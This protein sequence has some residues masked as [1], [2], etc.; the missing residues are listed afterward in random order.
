MLMLMMFLI[1][2]GEDKTGFVLSRMEI[3]KRCFLFPI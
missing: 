3:L 1:V 2:G